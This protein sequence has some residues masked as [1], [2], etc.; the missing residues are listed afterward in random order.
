MREGARLAGSRLLGLRFAV[1]ASMLL[2]I[3]SSMLPAAAQSPPKVFRIGH[4]AA[5]S[6]TPDGAPPRALREALR[7]LGYVDTMLPFAL[8]GWI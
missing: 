5:P 7:E 3:F 2:G 1:I 6:R 8:E 4:L